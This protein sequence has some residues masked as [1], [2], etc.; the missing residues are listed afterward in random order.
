MRKV[1]IVFILTVLIPSLG[2]AWL[3]IRSLRD[4]QYSLERQ[5]FLLYQSAVDKLA[6]EAEGY[7]DQQQ[8]QFATQVEVMLQE[9]RPEILALSFDETIRKA[10]PMAEIGFAVSLK[11]KVINPLLTGR[12]EA[13]QFRLENDR[14]L[15]NAESVEVYWN[16]GRGS[17]NLSALDQKNS[18][19]GQNSPQFF[20]AQSQTIVPIVQSGGQSQSQGGQGGYYGTDQVQ[21]GKIPTAKRVVIPQSQ[22]DPSQQAIPMPPL[23]TDNTYSR[24]QAS[25]AEFHQLIGEA[26]EGM[27]A[28]FLQN[29]LN[30]MTWYRSPRNSNLVYGAKLD[31]SKLTDGLKSVVHTL[32]PELG[33]NVCVALLDDSARP[34]SRSHPDFT[35]SWKRPFVAAEIGEALPHW[36]I[37][38]YQ[39]NPGKLNSAAVTLKFTLALLVSLLL[40]AIIIGGW[41][42]G[43]DLHRELRLARQKTDFVSNVSHELKTPLTSIR[44]FAELLADGRVTDPDKQRG[45][46]HII[47]AESARLTRLINNVLDF[48]R[49]ERGEKKYQMH[50]LD[51]ATVTRDS[52]EALR[53]HLESHGFKLELSLPETP[54]YVI[55]DADALAQIVVNLLSNAEKYSGESHDIRLHLFVAAYPFPHAE[56][57]VLDRGRGV[58]K[59]CE[60]K[61][62]EQFYRA[63]D[64][65]SSGIQGSGLGLTLA[66]Q[67]ARAHGGE[68]KYIAREGGGSCF[69]LHLPLATPS[70]YQT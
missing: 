24:V 20:Q 30:V 26:S 35:A 49:L 36:E 9:S 38:F 60:E 42:I 68:L 62:F 3:A 51:V 57:Q 22:T 14:F 11:G 63:H 23:P 16:T 6:Q 18:L 28:R 52:A 25:E 34:V 8:Q 5:E 59:G 55:G 13:R 64:S 7:L 40:M 66:R 58:P 50:Q 67:I 61:I 1:A 69:T 70:S 65:L 56:L 29:R 4:Q 21:S 41:L 48:A 46:L 47:T 39:L 44:M 53:A 2:L 43:R 33:G 10:W 15:C 27:M 17:V 45:Y 12:P 19:G 31:L 37:A 54:V 32:N